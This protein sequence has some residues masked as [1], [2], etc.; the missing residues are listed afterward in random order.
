MPRL[1]HL[2]VEATTEGNIE[3]I[4]RSIEDGQHGDSVVIII[5]EQVD[6]LIK[7]LRDAKKLALEAK[8]Q[9]RQNR[10]QS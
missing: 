6:I 2:E 1:E 9:W 4:Q 10:N 5:P 7:W 3:I 8:K